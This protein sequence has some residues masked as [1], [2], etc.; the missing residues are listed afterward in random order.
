MKKVK[1]KKKAN[2]K[3][4]IALIVILIILIYFIKN[5]YQL[6]KEPT[7]IFIIEQGKIELSE[8]VTRFYYS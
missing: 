7:N 2:I 1:T 5:I 3:S 6:I 8:G 4:I